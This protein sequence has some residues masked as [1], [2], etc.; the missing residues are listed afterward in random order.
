[1]NVW[2]AAEID[3][4][5][6]GG[7]LEHLSGFL[8]AASRAGWKTVLSV[9]QPSAA[10]ARGFEAELDFLPGPGFARQ[11][12]FQ[13]NLWKEW[14]RRLSSGSR[15][16]CIYVR[17]GQWLLAPA[18]LARAAGIPLF[19]EVNG[20]IS[21]QLLAR[22]LPAP[23]I[24]ASDAIE[25]A[26]CNHADGVIAI[27]PSVAEEL[28]HRH[29]AGAARM[30]A[31]PSGIDCGEFRPPHDEAERAANRAAF[32]LGPGLVIGFVGTFDWWQGLPNLLR[33]FASI[34]RSGRGADWQCVLAGYGA[35]EHA[36]R[37]LAGQLGIGDCV[38]FPGK[39]APSSVP[40]FMRA[41][42]VGVLPRDDYAPT[43]TKLLQYFACGLASVY[44]A[45]P[46]LV[47]LGEAGCSYAPGVAPE[48]PEGLAGALLK[49]KD[50]DARHH[51]GRRSRELSLR[52][53]DWSVIAARVDILVRHAVASRKDG[54]RG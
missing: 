8:N 27:S 26:V 51:Y 37:E 47:W 28:I 25:H 40:A 35:G 19:L 33:A 9:P 4:A 5:Q 52:T 53:L 48:S 11:I 22:N 43:P 32:G 12:H 34:R 15:P 18:L 39:I 41:L 3:L 2:A 50:A 46:D 1:M 23:L 17:E 42:D 44:P 10:P 54:M 13:R 20:I 29:G 21:K 14:R 24:R 36:L 6:P 16:D 49:L 31:I 38:M 30:H 7:P 45:L